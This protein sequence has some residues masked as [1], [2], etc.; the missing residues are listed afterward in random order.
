MK[1]KSYYTLL[2]KYLKME[3]NSEVKKRVSLIEEWLKENKIGATNIKTKS[4]A[5]EIFWVNQEHNIENSDMIFIRDKLKQIPFTISEGNL[6]AKLLEYFHGNNKYVDY[7]Q[8]ISEL[9][10]TGLN[11]SPNAC[12]GKFELLYRII[13]PESR[14]PTKG[15]ILDNGQKYEL[16]GKTNDGGVRISDTE[17]TG[18]EYEKN[19]K[20][21]FT[22]K[23]NGNIVKKGGLKDTTVYEPEKIQYKQHYKAEFDKN[24]SLS[25]Q[26]IFSYLNMNGW[27]TTIKEVETIFLN[28]SWNQEIMNK[29]ILS[30]MFAKY[31]AKNGF[32][33]IIIFGD[34]TN[35]K[36]MKN[37]DDLDKI[38][39]DS[40]YFRINQP[41][42]VG[43]YII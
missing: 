34:G 17:L 37:V 11:T 26:L 43:W 2:Y 27:S 21:I 9:T 16:K 6:W 36:I 20:E 23:I 38:Q 4:I 25:K 35:V 28:D 39:I 7:L 29:I 5:Q 24:I 32:D 15:D 8:A 42:N 12:C 33:K 19:C 30:K 14:Q 10:P 41:L 1:Q 40:D 31:K 3:F 18:K 13:R 22:G